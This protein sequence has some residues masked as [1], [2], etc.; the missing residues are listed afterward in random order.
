M[1]NK[2]HPQQE[3]GRKRPP[4]STLAACWRFIVW[5]IIVPLIVIIIVIKLI[6]LFF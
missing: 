3:L 1:L 4:L 5:M 6:E 2:H